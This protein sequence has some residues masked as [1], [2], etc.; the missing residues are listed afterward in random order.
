MSERQ[1]RQ[2]EVNDLLKRWEKIREEISQLQQERDSETRSDERRRL[3]S[4][5]EERQVELQKVETQ[6]QL[7]EEELR[8][9]T[10]KPDLIFEAGQRERKGAFTE[11]LRVWQE[12]RQLYP[13]EPQSEQEIRRLTEKQQSAERL[14]ELIRR[15]TQRLREIKPI[16]PQVVRKLKEPSDGSI[17]NAALV[18]VVEQFL[19]DRLSAE[20]F[21]ETWKELEVPS[22]VSHKYVSRSG[23][24]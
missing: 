2:E 10:N 8:K 18:A 17:E 3:Q 1:R 16:Y 5:I 23:G 22:T 4:K 13:N 12:I 7:K 15:L 21:I 20:D 14:T 9:S 6:L 24:K 19:D 11:A